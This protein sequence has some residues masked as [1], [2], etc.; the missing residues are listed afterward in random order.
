MKSVTLLGGVG[1]IREAGDDPGPIVPVAATIGYTQTAVDWVKA[2]ITADAAAASDPTVQQLSANVSKAKDD[3]GKSSDGKLTK[4][5][6]QVIMQ[7][8]NYLL[9]G[10]KSA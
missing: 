1:I 5:Q 6:T 8:L 2:K 4:D 10:N 3:V 9:T 7:S